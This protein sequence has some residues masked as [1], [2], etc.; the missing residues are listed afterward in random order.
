MCQSQE[1]QSLNL[2]SMVQINFKHLA[3]EVRTIESEI[4]TIAQTQKSK[5]SLI[6]TELDTVVSESVETVRDLLLMRTN[7]KFN[8]SLRNAR[9]KIYS[10]NCLPK[11]AQE[12]TDSSLV[13]ML[14]SCLV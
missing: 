10:Q 13:E 7:A 8:E 4:Q 3:P 9:Q 5:V 12:Q 1:L 6:K 11:C 2:Q 14:G